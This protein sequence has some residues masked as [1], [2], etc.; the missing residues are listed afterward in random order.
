MTLEEIKAAV[1]SGDPVYWANISYKVIK[2]SLGQWFIRHDSG[3]TIGLVWSDG[4]TMNGEPKD[5]FTQSSLDKKREEKIQAYT[6]MH[7]RREKGPRY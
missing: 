3:N 5:F 2:D 4:K 7:E 6:E 1:E